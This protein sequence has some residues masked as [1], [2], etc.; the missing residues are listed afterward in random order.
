MSTALDTNRQRQ[1]V[2]TGKTAEEWRAIEHAAI[3][4]L[5]RRA[6]EA[7]ATV[8]ELLDRHGRDFNARQMAQIQRRLGK[9]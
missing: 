4:E 1:A 7:H 9:R 2:P 6:D 8:V 3:Q 5:R